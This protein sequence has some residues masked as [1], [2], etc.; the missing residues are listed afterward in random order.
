MS[1]PWSGDQ[2][3]GGEAAPFGSGNVNPPLD[4]TWTEPENPAALEA[5]ATWATVIFD[6]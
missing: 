4:A 5:E 3:P 6:S 2:L 1:T